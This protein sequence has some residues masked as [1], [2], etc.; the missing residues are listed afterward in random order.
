[1]IPSC[2]YAAHN[3]LTGN[4]IVYLTCCHSPSLS[5]H[6]SDLHILLNAV[7]ILLFGVINPLPLLEMNQTTTHGEETGC[8]GTFHHKNSQLLSM[9]TSKVGVGRV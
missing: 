1:M 8:L 3:S 7:S 4:V 9:S 2:I 5:N 6:R